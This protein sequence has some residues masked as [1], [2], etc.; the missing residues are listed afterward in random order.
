M[1]AMYVLLMESMVRPAPAHERYRIVCRAEAFMWAHVHDPVE[2]ER[3]A[4]AVHCSVRTLQSYFRE[5]FGIG[6]ARY[7]RIRR[8]NAVREVLLRNED[9]RPIIDIA[10]DYGFSH[11]GH[12]GAAYRA[13]FGTTPSATRRLR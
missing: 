7:F 12:F 11:Q 5:F 3:V 4:A 8:I 2:I 13:L 9:P 10:G 6:P 1:L